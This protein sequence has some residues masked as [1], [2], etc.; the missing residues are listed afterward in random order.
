MAHNKNIT[1]PLDVKIYINSYCYG[2]LILIDLV[3]IAMVAPK[4]LL[5]HIHKPQLLLVF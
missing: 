5:L 1:S 2:E 3:H 4:I